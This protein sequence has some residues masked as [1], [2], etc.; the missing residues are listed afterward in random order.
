MEY[1]AVSRL[2]P[3]LSFFW[4]AAASESSFRRLILNESLA[5]AATFHGQFAHA[6]T[7]E[8][9]AFAA[10]DPYGI[11]K[12]FYAINPTS[13]SIHF[14]HSVLEV[15]RDAACGFGQVYSI[16]AGC[17]GKF[18]L[19]L[20]THLV[21]PYH[22][23]PDH[24]S[25]STSTNLERTAHAVREKLE[26]C[27]RGFLSRLKAKEVYVT[28][29]GGLDSTLVA[30]LLKDQAARLGIKVVAFTFSLTGCPNA[31]ST[32]PSD[33]LLYARRVAEDLG[34][35]IKEVVVSTANVVAAVD[36]ALRA[37]MDWRDF[38]HHCALANIFLAR[39]ISAHAPAAP[40]GE[41]PV[42]FTGELMNELTAD[43]TTVCLDGAEYYPVP[44][45]SKKRLQRLY[46]QGMD[47]TSR[48][49]GIFQA[50]G[51]QV[52][53][54]YFCVSEDYLAIPEQVLAEPTAKQTISQL[55]ASDLVPDY[56]FKRKKVREQVGSESGGG[57]LG[58]MIQ[59]GITQDTLKRRF[60]DSF[61]LPSQLPVEGIFQLGRYRHQAKI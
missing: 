40:G 58:T 38:N 16:P 41:L 47:S 48:E 18:D 17:F 14:G 32:E 4:D 28:L 51:I 43:Y 10:R 5:E 46:L 21:R 12:L 57:I 15:M 19:R 29:S 61:S 11:Q 3:G 1:Q 13:R 56:I 53:E 20:G 22:F 49:T 55:A 31:S 33:D 30:A 54:I 45:I 26:K 8:G 42:V 24:A 59:S 37:G 39:A 23:L 25:F 2:L 7:A 60:V 36:E 52:L 9:C 44:K 27:L 50:Y 34:M 35:P 6:W